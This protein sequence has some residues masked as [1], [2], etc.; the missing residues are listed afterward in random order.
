MS[1]AP[2]DGGDPITGTELAV[3]CVSFSLPA[4]LLMYKV[5]DA[6]ATYIV[7]GQPA[8]GWSP[9]QHADI[10]SMMAA[11]FLGGWSAFG[12][13]L[14]WVMVPS[15]DA[16]PARTPA[17]WWPRLWRTVA[18]YAAVHVLM[19]LLRA[20][21][22]PAGG[23]TP[24]PY[25]TGLDHLVLMVTLAAGG[26]PVE[27]P[28]FVALPFAVA[29]LVLG[30]RRR[31]A[32]PAAARRRAL[33]LLPEII[34]ISS[35]LRG[36]LHLYQGWMAAG[37]AIV[38]GAGACLIYLRWRSITGLI[39]GHIAF[40]VIFADLLARLDSPTIVYAAIALTVAAGLAAVLTPRRHR[41]GAS[42]AA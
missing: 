5:A 36:A 37:A 25:P 20:A 4:A 22:D 35:A 28:V 13:F 2:P 23:A 7:G 14:L 42:N 32:G 33:W 27:E 8:A 15:D 39:V 34:V 40:N 41:P 10:G 38:W 6:I 29:A 12:A 11:L 16:S 26:G 3:V 9:A 24:G 30:R 1:K 18:A 21:L 19:V 17:G 31:Q